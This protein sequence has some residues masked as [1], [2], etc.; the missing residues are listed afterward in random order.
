LFLRFNRSQ[1][2]EHWILL[3]SFTILAITGLVQRYSQVAVVAFI[4]NRLF[5][6]I[7]S[8]RTVH[9]LAAIVFALQ[10]IYHLWQILVMWFAKREKGGMLLRMQ[11]LKDL[12]QILGFN[13]GIKKARPRYDRYT[14]EEKIEYWALVWGTIVMGVTGFIQWFPVQ[15]TQILPGDS[16]P[17][18]RSIHSWEAILAILSIAIWHGYHTIIKERNTSIF[19]GYMTEEEMEENHSLEYRRILAAQAYLKRIE[20]NIQST[21]PTTAEEITPSESS[22]APESI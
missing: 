14:V 22:E 6:G 21:Q 20:A 8:T 11:D 7:E 1:Q 12:L 18:S 9:H 16:I 10:S 19:T 4:I 3:F 5:G 17:V 13:L 2:V 15:A